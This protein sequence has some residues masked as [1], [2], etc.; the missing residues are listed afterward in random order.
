[1]SADGFA[2]VK[3]DVSY[4]D[5]H[6]SAGQLPMSVKRMAEIRQAFPKCKEVVEGDN[7]SLETTSKQL[8]AL[9]PAEDT[10]EPSTTELIEQLVQLVQTINWSSIQHN[11]GA[12]ESLTTIEYTLSHISECLDQWKYASH[13]YA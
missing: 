6:F 5:F 13:T 8:Y 7:S 12:M 4:R 2:D 3:K 11:H 1:M 9:E 10:D